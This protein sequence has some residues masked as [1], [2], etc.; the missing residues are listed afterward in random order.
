[1]SAQNLLTVGFNVAELSAEAQEVLAIVEKLYAELKKYDGMKVSPIS[2]SGVTELV[3]AVKSQQTSMES[4]QTTIAD[5][6]LAMKTYNQVAA[7]TAKINAKIAVSDSELGKA[8][9]AAKVQLQENTRALKEKAQ[10]ANQDFQL[11]KAI[12]EEEKQLRKDAVAA[13]KQ[14]AKDKSDADKAYTKEYERL[15]KERD[16]AAK[17]ADADQKKRDAEQ[18]K[19]K[20]AAG[21]Q[22][23][24][25]SD[26][27]NQ[28]VNKRK[29][30]ETK[31]ANALISKAPKAE[32]KDLAKQLQEANAAIKEVDK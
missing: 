12:E 28:L 13:E 1:M 23:V 7:E 19:Q 10:A 26:L 21:K 22:A 4:L 29:D 17:K 20:V 15:L 24:K 3:A 31:Y 5:L 32:Q 8:N 9:A 6:G 14:A 25:D 27:Y 11:R 16:A 30:L 2:A 18:A